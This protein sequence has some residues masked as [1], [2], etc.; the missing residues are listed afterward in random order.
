MTH[1]SPQITHLVSARPMSTSTGS[2]IR[3]LKSYI[4]D[5][6]ERNEELPEKDVSRHSSPVHVQSLTRHFVS[7][8]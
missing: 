1:I 3:H 4:T 2:A 8:G 6:S 5:L 7:L